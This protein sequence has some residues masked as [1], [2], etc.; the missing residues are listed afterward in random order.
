MRRLRECFE[1]SGH[2]CLLLYG[3]FLFKVF[4]FPGSLLV[5]NNVN[6]LAGANPHFIYSGNGSLRAEQYGEI[7]F[8]HQNIMEVEYLSGYE[9]YEMNPQASLPSFESVYN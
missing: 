7:W 4:N 5:S 1:N 8:R 6:Y 3:R 2:T 9:I